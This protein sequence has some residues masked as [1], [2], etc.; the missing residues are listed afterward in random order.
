M[1]TGLSWRK[2]GLWFDFSGASAVSVV[3]ACQPAW[4]ASAPKAWPR[5]T[6][7]RVEA[8]AKLI[9]KA[10][11][12]TSDVPRALVPDSRPPSLFRPIMHLRLTAATA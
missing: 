8:H 12:A 10:Y 9:L 1:A 3:A 11:E 5:S 7:G 2:A 4:L 6:L